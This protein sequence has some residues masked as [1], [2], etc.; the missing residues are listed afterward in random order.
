MAEPAGTDTESAEAVRFPAAAVAGA[1]LV[2]LAGVLAFS[3]GEPELWAP[4]PGVGTILGF[5]GMPPFLMAIA[6]LAF[7]IAPWTAERP[8]AVRPSILLLVLIPL[9]AFLNFLWLRYEREGGYQY[10]GREHTLWVS[11]ASLGL[12]AASVLLLLLARWR[13]ARTTYFA[14]RL[15]CSLWL[16]WAAFPYLGETP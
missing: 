11:A 7:F 15:L 12:S 2:G 3:A 5:L 4:Y 8:K 16:A 10:Q 14:G 6:W 9:L 1:I 13:P